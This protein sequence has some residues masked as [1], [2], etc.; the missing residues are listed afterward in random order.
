MYAY[1]SWAEE[2]LVPFCNGRLNLLPIFRGIPL[3]NVSL[4]VTIPP[5]ILVPCS[6]IVCQQIVDKGRPILTCDISSTV[7]T[8]GLR[9]A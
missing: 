7:G 6:K 8:L 4:F 3:H 2:A 5:A 1:T 9:I